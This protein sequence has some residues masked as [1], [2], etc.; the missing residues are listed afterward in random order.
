MALTSTQR[1]QVRYYLG[2]SDVSQGGDPNRLETAMTDITAAAEVIV[3]TILTALATIETSLT[4]ATSST[5]AG[6]VSV[7]NGGVVWGADGMSAQRGLYVEGRR[8]CGRLAVMFGVL[9]E[10]DVFG[11]GLS[12]SGPCGRG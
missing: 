3:G 7:D 5:R 6:I 9:V 8:Q 4:S 2:M 11:S 10:R 12:T 1:A